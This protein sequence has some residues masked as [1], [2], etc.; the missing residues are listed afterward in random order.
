VAWRLTASTLWGK[1]RALRRRRSI[2]YGCCQGSLS[3]FARLRAFSSAQRYVSRAWRSESV[4][5]GKAWSA[6]AV[7]RETAASVG[8][9]L[10][11]LPTMIHPLKRACS[12][13]RQRQMLRVAQREEEEER[14]E[15]CTL[16]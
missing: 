13:V 4:P 10:H 8:L 9:T 5:S 6:R 3:R 11:W 16:R 7:G 1:R 12:L 14:D 15:A 2:A